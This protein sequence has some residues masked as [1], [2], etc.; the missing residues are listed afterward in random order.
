MATMRAVTGRRAIIGAA[1]V[2][3]LGC[4]TAAAW[5]SGNGAAHAEA[6]IF[7]GDGQKVGTARLTEDAGGAVHVNVHVKGLSPGL[8]G[9]HIHQVAS[10][11]G[12]A[13]ASA[14]GHH[15]PTGAAHGSESDQLNHPH[16]GD[17]PN[18]V[19]NRNGVGH[20]NAKTTHATLTDGPLSVF[21]ANG[22]ALIIH[23][24]P[25]DLHTDPTGNSGG[26]VACGVIEG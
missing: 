18:L 21:D 12:P 13:F 15:N 8:H 10:C 4:G 14:G 9:I 25:D 24:M 20:L 22:S 2:L 1:A 26:R 11:V 16:A 23:A 17:L 3:A 19:V 5:P 7:D 6:T